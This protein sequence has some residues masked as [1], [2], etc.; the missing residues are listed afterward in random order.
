LIRAIEQGSLPVYALFFCLAGAFLNIDALKEM[1]F[2]AL[3]LVLLRMLGLFGATYVG[4]RMG[5]ATAAMRQYG[6]LGFVA[7]AGVSLGLATVL[8]RVFPEWGAPLQTLIIAMVA[9]NQLIGP[10]GFRFALI[11]SREAHG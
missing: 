4:A 7:Q 8:L 10:I 3:V 6:W 2:L 9:I 5:G 11:R 1:W